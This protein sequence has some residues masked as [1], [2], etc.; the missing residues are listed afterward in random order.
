MSTVLEAAQEL[1]RQINSPAVAHAVWVQT[2]VDP[3][4]KEFRQILKVSIR[5]G[6]KNKIKIPT[7]CKGHP[8]VE[9]PWPKAGK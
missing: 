2:V 9:E 1:I 8:V 4:T 6:W 5:P 3:E 7:E